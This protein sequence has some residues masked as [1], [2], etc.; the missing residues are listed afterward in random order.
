MSA[1]IPKPAEAPKKKPSITLEEG[2]ALAAAN[3]IA[4]CQAAARKNR[5]EGVDMPPALL[6]LAALDLKYHQQAAP[7]APPPGVTP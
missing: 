6:A 1:P 5:R 4:G 7:A 2:Q 3:D